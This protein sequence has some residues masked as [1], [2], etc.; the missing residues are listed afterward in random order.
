M[1]DGA[2]GGGETG[3]TTSGDVLAFVPLVFCAELLVVCAKQLGIAVLKT[4]VVEQSAAAS[5]LNESCE[6]TRVPNFSVVA[7][8]PALVLCRN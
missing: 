6:Q 3:A 5:L 1:I 4:N 8:A 2:T 7:A